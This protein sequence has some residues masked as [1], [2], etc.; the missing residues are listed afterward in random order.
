[1]CI[2]I[3]LAFKNI[4]SSNCILSI[5]MIIL[6]GLPFTWIM[7]KIVDV[8]NRRC[9]GCGGGDDGGGDDGDVSVTTSS[10]MLSFSCAC[11][12]TTF[13]TGEEFEAAAAFFAA[14]F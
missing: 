1:M 6:N 14:C 5:N 9:G 12:C 3:D 8:I 7:W 4:C 2:R 10:T 11:S 13:S